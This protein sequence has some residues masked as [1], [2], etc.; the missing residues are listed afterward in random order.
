MKW[1]GAEEACPDFQRILHS[2]VLNT[3]NTVFISPGYREKMT[4][5]K[6]I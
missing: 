5:G 3:E 2:D 6:L 1:Q 4:G